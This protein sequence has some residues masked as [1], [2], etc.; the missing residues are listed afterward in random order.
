[1]THQKMHLPANI[2]AM[3]NRL[4][5]NLEEDGWDILREPEGN[6][7]FYAE[8]GRLSASIEYHGTDPDCLS[9]WLFEYDGEGNLKDSMSALGDDFTIRQCLQY[10]ID[11]TIFN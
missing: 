2:V 8:N 6:R 7:L 1:M 3:V 9:C 11:P 10:A 5:V 4:L